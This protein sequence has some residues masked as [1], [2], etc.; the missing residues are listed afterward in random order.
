M[1]RGGRR[2]AARCFSLVLDRQRL[3]S[4]AL[5]FQSDPPSPFPRMRGAK[6]LPTPRYCYG[7]F[8]SPP[9]FWAKKPD[10][11]AKLTEQSQSGDYFSDAAARSIATTCASVRSGCSLQDTINGPTTFLTSRTAFSRN[12]LDGATRPIAVMMLAGSGPPAGDGECEPGGRHSRQSR[13][14]PPLRFA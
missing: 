6:Q 8:T 10:S 14:L 2:F 3:E 12:S 11:S 9:T 7:R 5:P 4:F 13:P 1:A